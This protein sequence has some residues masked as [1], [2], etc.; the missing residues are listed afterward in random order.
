MIDYENGHLENFASNC[1]C[2]INCACYYLGCDELHV[3]YRKKNGY[4][5]LGSEIMNLCESV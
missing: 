1:D 5:K 3:A 2:C 4:V